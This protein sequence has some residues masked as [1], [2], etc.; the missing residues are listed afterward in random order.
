MNNNNNNNN[1]NKNI[2]THALSNPPT[3]THLIWL[4]YGRHKLFRRIIIF[5]K[6][7]EEIAEESVLF[8]KLVIVSLSNRLFCC[9]SVL[10]LQENVPVGGEVE[11]EEE[12]RERRE[13][14]NYYGLVWLG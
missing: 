4:W 9:C 3:P 1:N 6:V 13:T 11:V 8:V 12:E 10:K 5:F 2:Y 7:C 14:I